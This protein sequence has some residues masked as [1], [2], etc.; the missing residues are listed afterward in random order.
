MQHV[1]L[2]KLHETLWQFCFLVNIKCPKMLL[3]YMAKLLNYQLRAPTLW[4][5]GSTPANEYV[6]QLMMTKITPETFAHIHV[7]NR[8]SKSIAL[9]IEKYRQLNIDVDL[10]TGVGVC[11]SCLIRKNN[12]LKKH[13]ITSIFRIYSS[14]DSF[15]I[16]WE[17]RRNIYN[18]NSW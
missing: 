12:P 15:V 8:K 10:Q 11:K 3:D 16:S 2:S 6:C 1:Y 17:V 18:G 7:C 4:I 13:F 9:L 14:A 5:P